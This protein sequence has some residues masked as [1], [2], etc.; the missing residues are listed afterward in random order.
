MGEIENATESNNRR[1]TL[2]ALR[3]KIARSLDSTD[4]ARDIA[5][6]SNRLLEVMK[7]L[8]ALPKADAKKSA[9][10]AAREKRA[11]ND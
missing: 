1:E 5:A 10:A 7:E 8:D 6:L 2:E 11:A 4:S 3:K 9:L